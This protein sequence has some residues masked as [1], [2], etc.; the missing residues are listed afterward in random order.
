MPPSRRAGAGSRRK[1]RVAAYCKDPPRGRSVKRRVPADEVRLV[2]TAAA[3]SEEATAT[4]LQRFR[5]AICHAISRFAATPTDREDLHSEVVMRLLSDDKR[6]LRHWQPHA[7]FAAYV[8]SIAAHHCID[9]LRGEGRLPPHAEDTAALGHTSVV[10]F[11]EE[12]MPAPSGNPE[13]ALDQAQFRQAVADALQELS[14]DD[15]LILYMRYEQES[16]GVEIASALGISHVA[17]R[18]RIYRALR[19]L[20]NTLDD[21]PL[22]DYD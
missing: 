6:A 7:P 5:G 18:Q 16:T 10:D 13:E 21:S 8:S 19:R 20:E 12:T 17:A 1:K 2:K 9:W 3:C 14:A 15:R 22:I 4:L 11:L